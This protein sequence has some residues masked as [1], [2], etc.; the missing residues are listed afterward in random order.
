MRTLPGTDQAAFLAHLQE[1]AGDEVEVSAVM[2]MPPVEAAADA[3][4]RGAIAGGAASRRPGERAA[5][6]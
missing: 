4:D 1:V 5:R 3:P 2:T 6:R